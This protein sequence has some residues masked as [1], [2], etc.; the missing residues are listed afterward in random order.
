VLPLLRR[1]TALVLGAAAPQLGTPATRG[2]SFELL[3]LDFVLSASPGPGPGAAPQLGAWLIECNENPSVDVNTRV[4]EA[5]VRPMLEGLF[6]IVLRG[7]DGCVR[8]VFFC[9]V[10]RLFACLLVLCVALRSWA[11]CRLTKCKTITI[12]GSQL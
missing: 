5:M 3:G 1:A 6:D 9:F 10:F 4:K 8:L 11:G 2:R 12:P 7:W